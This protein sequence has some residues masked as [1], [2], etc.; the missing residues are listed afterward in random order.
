M[1]LAPIAGVAGRDEIS[2]IICPAINKGHDV[3]YFKRR[4]R[5]RSATVHALETITLEY[6][7]AYRLPCCGVGA[8]RR[9]L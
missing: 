2:L 7:P 3:I 6:A 9:H 1:L 8:L 5:R 4:I